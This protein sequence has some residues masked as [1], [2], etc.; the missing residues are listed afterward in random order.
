MPAFLWTTRVRFVDT[1]ASQRIHYTALFRFFE[2][3]EHEF[4]RDL[5]TGYPEM[6]DRALAW[7]RV[8]AECDISGA[9]VFDDEI[10]IEVAVERVGTTS[11]ALRFRAL[12]SGVECG[13]GTIVIVC[14]N[15]A[16]Q[17]SQPLP[18]VFAEAL[19]S[20]Q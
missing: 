11:F 2:A 1:D 10:Q 18:T 9:L 12:K 13:T 20:R 17:K 7:P 3:A 16:A 15:V 14:M 5:E 19:R 8:H 6:S 4:F